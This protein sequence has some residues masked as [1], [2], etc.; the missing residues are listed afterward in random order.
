MCDANII[1]DPSKTKRGDTLIM[2]ASYYFMGQ[3]SRFIPPGSRQIGL[4]STV[5]VPDMIQLSDV[6]GKRLRFNP[7]GFQS[8]GQTWH[9]DIA[10]KTLGVY[11]LC[12]QLDEDGEG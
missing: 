8:A 12:A 5:K 9:Y 4:T 11:D 6:L 2:Q 1:V 7:C 3:F 10:S